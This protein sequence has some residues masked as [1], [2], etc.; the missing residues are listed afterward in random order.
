MHIVYSRHYDI[1]CFGIERLHPFDSKKYGRAWRVLRRQFGSLLLENH[2]PVD[3]PVS[4]EELSLVHSKEYLHS[5]RLPKHIAAALEIPMLRSLPGWL[6][7]WRVLGPMK[8]AA[9]GSVLAA[10]AALKNGWSVNLSGGYHHAQ[11]DHGEGFCV[12]SDIALIVGQLRR[13]HLVMEI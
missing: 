11:P 4:D 9:R 10:Q 7:R 5:L 1:S 13:E 3:R 2:I 6:L 8:W 12:F